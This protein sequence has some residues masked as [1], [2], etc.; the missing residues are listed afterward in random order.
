MNKRQQKKRTKM[1]NKKLIKRYPF[2]LPRNCWTGK[3][4]DDY[5][6]S[7]TE[8]DCIDIGWRKAFGKLLLE[9]LREACIKTNYLYELRLEQIKEK[10]GQLRI[11]TNAAP[12]EIH[13]VIRKYEFIS[14]YVCIHCGKPEAIVVNNYGW[15]LP[16]CKDCWNASNKRRESKELETIPWKIASHNQ[17]TGLPDSYKL[18]IFSQ[19]KEIVKEIDI[20]KTTKKIKRKYQK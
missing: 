18:T 20:S 15:M 17:I 14:E 3:V 7:Y 10:Y 12:Q 9:D 5:D 13:D 19:G 11:Y 6:Y 8:Y 4:V 16:L 2:L 1:Q